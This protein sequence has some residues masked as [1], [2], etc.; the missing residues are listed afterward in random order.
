MPTYSFKKRSGKIVD[1]F[2]SI[3][4]FTRRFGGLG[5]RG[6]LADGTKAV[7]VLTSAPTSPGGGK[8]KASRYPYDSWSM[9]CLPSQKKEMQDYLA[10]QGCP[11]EVTPSGDLTIRSPGHLRKVHKAL[12][13]HDKNGTF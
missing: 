12:G 4:E 13:V 9:G 1:E 5:G 2:M 8:N 10:G 7:A 11:T 6:L 3:A